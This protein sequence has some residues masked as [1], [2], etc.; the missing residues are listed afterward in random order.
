ML[1]K[2]ELKGIRETLV[3]RKDIIF[4]FHGLTT[5]STAKKKTKTLYFALD[6]V[7]RNFWGS[8]NST[9]KPPVTLLASPYCI[10]RTLFAPRL[11]DQAVYVTDG[12]LLGMPGSLFNYLVHAP[13]RRNFTS[14]ARQWLRNGIFL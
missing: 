5:I 9:Q 3:S 1:E 13:L 11:P 7:Q 14:Y 2:R 8:Q 4:K 10:K 6:I 12:N